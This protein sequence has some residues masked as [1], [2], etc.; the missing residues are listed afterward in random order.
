[1]ATQTKNVAR[2]V[3]I[4]AR[5]RGPGG[6]P[7]DREQTHQ[8]IRHNLIE[9][10]YE[11]IEALDHRDMGAFRDELG[12]IL[13]QVVFHSQM[14]SERGDFDFDAVARSISD[15][16][17]HRHPHVFGK[18]KAR[19]SA[20]V[21]QQWEAIKKSE[22]GASSIVH[23][24][25]LPKH[26]PALLKADKVQRKVARVG[27]DWKQVDD[28]VAKVEEEV[29]ELKG[30]LASKSRKQFEE[31]VGDLLFAVVNLAR[32]EDLQAEDLLNRS[33]A[34]FV[35]RFQQIETSVHASGRRLEDCTLEELDALWESA[36]HKEQKRRRKNR[37]IA[38][39]RR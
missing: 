6:C 17:V 32:F 23:L 22:K 36:K 29:R 37:R 2:L 8:S 13:L 5:L 19:N 7:W 25:D 27:F 38:G 33:I 10:C 11:A 26:L 30:A 24:E 4:M 31:E 3:K 28:V 16:L 21:L 18:A 15:K 12:D 20:E 34:K 39:S 14:A 1:M 9:E 35:K